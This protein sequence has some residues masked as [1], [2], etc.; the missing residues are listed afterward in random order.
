[1][2]FLRHDNYI[3]LQKITG[4]LFC[5][6]FVFVCQGKESKRQAYFIVKY[7]DPFLLAFSVFNETYI[8][9]TDCVTHACVKLEDERSSK[10]SLNIQPDLLLSCCKVMFL[11]FIFQNSSKVICPFHVA[12]IDIMTKLRQLTTLI[13]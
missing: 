1:M 7:Q 13:G 4:R 9:L 11:S 10:L 2:R 3:S 5:S 6:Q 12:A 8:C